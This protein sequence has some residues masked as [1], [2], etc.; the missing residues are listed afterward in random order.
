[1]A[2][3]SFHISTSSCPLC[4]LAGWGSGM[5]Q[6]KIR[7]Q[8]WGIDLLLSMLSKGRGSSESRGCVGQASGPP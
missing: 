1:M 3:L 4:G 6:L 2:H 7:A 8:P 5:T